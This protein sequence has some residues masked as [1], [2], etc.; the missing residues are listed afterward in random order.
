MDIISFNI[1]EYATISL[2]Q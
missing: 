2:I 1:N